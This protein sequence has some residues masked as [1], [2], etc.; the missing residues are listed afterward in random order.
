LDERPWYRELVGD[1]DLPISSPRPP[2]EPTAA[3]VEVTLSAR[4][5]KGIS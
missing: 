5:G 2:G 3:E 4:A 1:D